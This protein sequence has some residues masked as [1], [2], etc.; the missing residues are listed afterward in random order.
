MPIAP[1]TSSTLLESIFPPYGKRS[2]EVT[3]NVPKMWD[4]PSPP[5]DYGYHVPP[6]NQ[7]LMRSLQEDRVN[8]KSSSLSLLF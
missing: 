3:V 5:E 4:K 8:N 2:I 6:K 7:S 1:K